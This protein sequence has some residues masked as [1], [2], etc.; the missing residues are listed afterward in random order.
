MSWKYFCCYFVWS[1]CP[2][3]EV[4]WI[5]PIF[6]VI[7]G[8]W[9]LDL[10]IYDYPHCFAIHFEELPSCFVLIQYL[11][12]LCIIKWFR[13]GVLYIIPIFGLIFRLGLLTLSN[14]VV[15]VRPSVCSGHSFLKACTAMFMVLNG[16][17]GVP[18]RLFFW[19]FRKF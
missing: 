3:K 5:I 9:V 2:N 11:W 13:L 18:Y 1:N 19:N 14:G 12:L 17:Y 6:W 4:I 8:R 7:L 10:H 15:C 16:H